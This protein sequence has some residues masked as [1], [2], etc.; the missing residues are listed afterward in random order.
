M[1]LNEQRRAIRAAARERKKKQRARDQQKRIRAI[2]AQQASL[3]R[4]ERRARHL[5]FFGECAP[6][7]NA[8]TFEDELQIHREFL[9]GL[10]Q[11]D[12]RLPKRYAKS[13][14]AHIKLGSSARS[15][16]ATVEQS[17]YR[18]STAR[19][20]SSILSSASS[21]ATRHSMKSGRRRRIAAA[22]NPLTWRVC[23][24]C[25]PCRRHL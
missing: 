13:Q 17:T 9:R 14:G 8:T 11:P 12:V 10:G 6:G 1:E 23:R 18:D 25:R 4:V 15:P 5:H 3:E 22:T 2:E 20:S 16:V 21:S 19:R 24:T 7:R